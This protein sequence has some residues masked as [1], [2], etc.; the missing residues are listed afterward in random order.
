MSA[1]VRLEES[2]GIITIGSFYTDRMERSAYWEEIYATR[3]P[4]EVGWFESD[5][6]MSRRFVARALECGARTDIDV[7]GGASHLVDY[8]LDLKL[9]RV[10]VLDISENGLEIA[11][12]RLG[13]RAN[14][15]EWI[16][17]DLTELDDVGEFDVWHDRAAFHFLIDPADRERYVHLAERSLGPGGTAI[18]ATFAPDGPDKCSGLNVCHYDAHDLAAVCGPGFELVDTEG[19]VHTTP[20]GVS[21]SFVYSSFRRAA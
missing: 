21:Q 6:A 3:A 13:D 19:Y 1:E 16:V 14:R 20:H 8:L 12:H 17:G 15:V 7:G 2:R 11:K 9:E 5:P 18:M 4:D 10:V